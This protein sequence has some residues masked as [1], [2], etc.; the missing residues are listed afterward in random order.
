MKTYFYKMM[1]EFYSVKEAGSRLATHKKKIRKRTMK[2]SICALL[3]NVLIK[4]QKRD[5][6]KEA[7][8]QKALFLA[9]KSIFGW[10]RAMPDLRQK[11]NLFKVI[12]R[13]VQIKKCLKVI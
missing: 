13:E 12:K 4:N 9:R 2:K 10:I 11:N 3:Q 5:R 8:Y 7:D 1:D 6:L